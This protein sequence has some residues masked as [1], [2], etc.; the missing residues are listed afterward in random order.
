MASLSGTP[1]KH[2]DDDNDDDMIG[3]D[4]GKAKSAMHIH[5]KM[6]TGK[7]IILDVA[8]S[9]TIATVKTKIRGQ[10]SIPTHRQRLIFAGQQLEDGRTLSQYCI[11]HETTLHLIL[12]LPKAIVSSYQIFVKTLTGKTITLSV[13]SADSMEKVAAKIQDKE[14]IPPDQQRI[15]FAGKQLYG[16]LDKHADEYGFY[17]RLSDEELGQRVQ[18]NPNYY[19]DCHAAGREPIYLE[20]VLE[21]GSSAFIAREAA[22]STA[23]R[24]NEGKNQTVFK[25]Q[26]I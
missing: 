17:K 1:S 26:Y 7:R 6:L 2:H 12:R 19:Q 18:Q 11:Q 22:W 13:T 24:K 4:L 21:P 25:S 10:E 9:N 20:I 5:I 23:L 8:P 15:I 14:G 16:S 3:G